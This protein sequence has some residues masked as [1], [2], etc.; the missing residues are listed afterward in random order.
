MG[1]GK[2]EEGVSSYKQAAE[3]PDKLLQSIAKERL[4]QMQID[5]SI[6]TLDLPK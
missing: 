3:G 1:R 4:M 6:S 5:Q 2:T